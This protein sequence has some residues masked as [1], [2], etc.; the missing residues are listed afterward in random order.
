MSAPR[1]LATP[2]PRLA[3]EFGEPLVSSVVAELRAAG[4]SG[5]QYLDKP[6]LLRRLLLLRQ[7]ARS[8]RSEVAA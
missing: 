7:Q 1:N 3:L 2:Y 8:I 6:V 4:R 5:D